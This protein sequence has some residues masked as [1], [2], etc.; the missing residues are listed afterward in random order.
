SGRID[1]AYNTMGRL[2]QTQSPTVSVTGEDGATSS[3]RPTE[4]KYYDKSGRLVASKD[5]NGNLTRLTLLAGTGYDGAQALVTQVTTAYNCTVATAYDIQGDARKITDQS[6]RVTT[7]SFD[8]DGR[9]IEVDHA[10]GLNDYYQCD[11]LGQRIKHWNNLYGS[12][13][14]DLTTY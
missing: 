8:S 13:D 3:V 10:G 2:I 7:Q 4:Y 9:L 1:Y 14:A 5:A 6:G 12:S 11:V